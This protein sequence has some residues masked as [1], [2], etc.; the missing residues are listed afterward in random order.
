MSGGALGDYSYHHVS[1]F[2]ADL[3]VQIDFN[4]VEDEWGYCHNYSSE[5]IAFLEKE[6]EK[7][8]AM[9]K[10]M[11]HIDYLYSGDHSEESFMKIVALKQ[12]P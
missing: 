3:R 4:G 10:M 6:L 2:I 1:S 11:R 9:V 8:E 12:K 7:M 5:T